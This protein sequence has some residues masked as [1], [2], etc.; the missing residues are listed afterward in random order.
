MKVSIITVCYNSIATIRDT[1]QSVINQT[2]NQIEFIVVDG[3]STDGTLDVIRENGEHIHHWISEK[4]SGLY[5]AMNKG[6]SLATGDIIG[7]LNSDD[8]YANSQVIEKVVESFNKSNAQCVYGDLVYVDKDNTR[9]VNRYW[10]AGVATKRSFYLGWMPPHPSFFVKKEVYEQ[11]G[12]FDLQFKI[13]ADYEFML[14]IMLKHACSF[15]YLPEVITVMRLGGASNGSIAT[16]FVSYNENIRAWKV[17]RVSPW[18]F[19]VPFK[20]FR[21]FIQYPL[22]FFNGAPKEFGIS[23]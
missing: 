20:I 2:Y 4:D 6:I 14:R 7:I 21:K 11:C 12:N 15:Y 10:K 3:E 22:R 8:F 16:R 18:F 5:D 1:I 19:T 17:N 23:K 9:K 13:A